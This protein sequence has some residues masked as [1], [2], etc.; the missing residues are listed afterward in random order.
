MPRSGTSMVTN[1]CAEMGAYVENTN[2]D[3]VNKKGDWE[4]QEVL[5][6]NA[7]ILET[8][9]GA[10][11]NPPLTLVQ[12]DWSSLR[13]LNKLRNAAQRVMERLSQHP[14]W[15][16][17]DPKHCL[18]MGFWQPLLP[19][20]H[21]PYYVICI[22]NPVSITKSVRLTGWAPVSVP[23]ATKLWYI[24]TWNALRYT[25]NERR[26]VVFMD[27]FAED[28]EAQVRRLAGFLGLEHPAPSR[29]AFEGGLVHHDHP[30]KEFLD[31][32]LVPGDAK[33]LY[34]FLLEGSRTSLDDAFVHFRSWDKVHA[35]WYSNDPAA[36]KLVRL[37]MR[38]LLH[39]TRLSLPYGRIISSYRG[40]G[41]KP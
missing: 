19:R 21:T 33:R 39:T 16:L 26:L 36:R 20:S 11:F 34:A 30:I 12:R 25:E 5:D 8:L 14:V 23:E 10:P 35:D 4:S 29:S 24:Y 38:R 18:T 27:D 40:H 3:I 28:S 15:A 41:R 32:P 37:G 22:R 6:I 31:N 1:L 2:V 7:K 17:K 9:G 13:S